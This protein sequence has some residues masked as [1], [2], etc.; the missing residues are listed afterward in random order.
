MAIAMKLK[1]ANGLA[2]MGL[3]GLFALSAVA[4]NEAN[5]DAVELAPLPVPVEFVRD[6]DK[7]VAFD[8][9]ATVT[10][11]CPDAGAV[12]WLTRHFNDWYGAQAPKVAD[13]AAGVRALPTANY[14]LP[15]N[16]KSAVQSGR[17]C[18]F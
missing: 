17:L 12:A 1:F 16:K 15:T 13:G 10:V 11:E 9:T 8:A 3:A 5:P 2:V 4:G 6:M 14:Q 18:C 7:P